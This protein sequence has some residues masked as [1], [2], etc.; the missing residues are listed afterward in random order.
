ML[1]AAQKGKYA[2]GAFNINNLETL[3][4]IVEAAQE[5]RSPVIISTSEGAIE[6]AG[7]EYLY[8]MTKVA[9]AAKIP[10]A[11]HLDH[12]KNEKLVKQMIKLGHHT[13]VMFDGSSMDYKINIRKTRSIVK[14]A[15]KHRM[16]VEAELGSIAG[17]EDFVSVEEKDVH[18]TNPNQAADFVKRTGCDSIAIAIGTKHGAYKYQGAS[19]LD[20]DRLDAI[21]AAVSVPLVLHGASGIPLW[22][23]QKCTRAGC[24]IE[25]AKGVS[26]RD[27]QEAISRG[28]S[29]VNVDTDLRLAFTA[30]VRKHL[31]NY[32]ENIDPRKYLGE[33]R[34]LVK[35]V[36]KEKIELFGS[37]NKA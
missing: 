29:K 25:D 6:Y 26:N 24:A 21:R 20:F 13:S 28:I 14:L 19:K 23:K 32:P 5:E 34:E 8:A 22:L 18:L 27:V 35:R 15:H 36:V 12:G 17:I 31:N 10:I 1:R 2:I 7:I 30:A 4:A 37:K 16:Q 9:A 11:F 3:Q 33:A